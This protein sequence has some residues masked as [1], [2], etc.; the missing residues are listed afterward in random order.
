MSETRWLDAAEQRTWRTFMLATRL[1]F[2]EFERDLQRTAGMPMTY[3]EVLVRLS[4]APD[5]QMRMSELAE[6]AQNSRSRLSHAVARL[7]DAGWVQRRQCPSDRR[8]FLAVLTAEGQA[9]LEAAAPGHVDS[10]R[11]HLF[12]PLTTIQL[13]D[14]RSICE[15]I[16]TGLAE[17]GAVCATALPTCTAVPDAAATGAPTA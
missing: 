4:E 2:D 14:L 7:E 9:A 15:A 11:R 3:Y 16:L 5:G 8:G 12:D 17:S 13:D 10:V 1:L 6:L